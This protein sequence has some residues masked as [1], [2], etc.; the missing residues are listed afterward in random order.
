MGVN[1]VENTEL[2]LGM[3]QGHRFMAVPMLCH[4]VFYD[5]SIAEFQNTERHV[6]LLFEAYFNRA[7]YFD[8]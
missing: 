3:F 5:I 6:G 2:S 8:I 1:S 4:G 7:V